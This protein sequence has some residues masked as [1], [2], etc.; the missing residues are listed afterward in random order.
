MK[1]ANIILTVILSLTF[2]VSAHAASTVVDTT[3]SGWVWRQM[4]EY[5][6]PGL[7]AG[8]GRVGGPG[9]YAAYTS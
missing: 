6:D 7:A 2:A 3:K 4:S 9:S 1:C 5:D 8:Q